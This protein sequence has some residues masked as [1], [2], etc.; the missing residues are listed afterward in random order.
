MILTFF[1]TIFTVAVL[2]L[3][4]ETYFETK[5]IDFNKRKLASED[6]FIEIEIDY[7][8][9]MNIFYFL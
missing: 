5:R 1:K 6:I 4:T 9:V 2:L 8:I 7:V 3:L